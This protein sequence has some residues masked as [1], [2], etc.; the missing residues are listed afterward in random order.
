VIWENSRNP[1]DG[2]FFSN[3]LLK[4]LF[5]I[6]SRNYQCQ[7]KEGRLYHQIFVNGIIPKI[8]NLE[9]CSV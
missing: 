9:L 1:A 6:Q 2:L 5:L 4:I 3:L 8:Q 7:Y